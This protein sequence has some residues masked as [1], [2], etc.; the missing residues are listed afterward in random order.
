ME[1]IASHPGGGGGLGSDVGS[2]RRRRGGGG[3]AGRGRGSHPDDVVEARAEEPL[4]EGVGELGVERVVEVE[5]EAERPAAK[6]EEGEWAVS[7]VCA[8]R[9]RLGGGGLG[10]GCVGART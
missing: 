2:G 1:H 8:G 7:E 4:V 6:G 5:E 10:G 9:R 3:G